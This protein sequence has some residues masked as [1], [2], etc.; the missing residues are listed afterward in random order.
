ML[1]AGG[2]LLDTELELRFA[3]QYPHYLKQWEA[4]NRLQVM[5]QR[6][7]RYK[8]RTILGYKTLCASTINMVAAVQRQIDMELELYGETS[9]TS[10]KES[11]A[12]LA[13]VQ[14]QSLSSQPVDHEEAA[15]RLKTLSLGDGAGI[16]IS[17]NFWFSSAF[18]FF[19]RISLCLPSGRARQMHTPTIIRPLSIYIYLYMSII[20]CH[21]Y[22][23]C[24]GLSS[25]LFPGTFSSNL[26]LFYP[27]SLSL[28]PLQLFQPEILFAWH[29][30]L[31]LRNDD[32]IRHACYSWPCAR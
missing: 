32:I 29:D 28:S 12:P 9:S 17:R 16:I 15:E 21:Q 30:R 22:Q 4:G 19:P 25:P 26:F 24:G 20:K 14:V 18:P 27:F 31:T 23:L 13:R 8:N 11:V 1:P 6:R 7:K 5:L 10:G 3:L 2:G